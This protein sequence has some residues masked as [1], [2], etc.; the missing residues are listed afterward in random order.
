[1]PILTQPDPHTKR[2]LPWLW[3]LLAAA[4]TVFLSLTGFVLWSSQ[5]P[6]TFQ[7]VSIRVWAG[8]SLPVPRRFAFYRDAFIFGSHVRIRTFPVLGSQQGEHYCLVWAW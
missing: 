4:L 7:V 2:R 6:V 3:A 1:M 5:R 8:V